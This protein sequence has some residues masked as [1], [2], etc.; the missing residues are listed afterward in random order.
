MAKSNCE[1]YACAENNRNMKTIPVVPSQMDVHVPV[2]TVRFGGKEW[3]VGY[4]GYPE[5]EDEDGYKWY[6]LNQLV[7]A[8]RA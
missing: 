3:V 5:Y 7:R 4:Q 1:C 6:N 8:I 2:K